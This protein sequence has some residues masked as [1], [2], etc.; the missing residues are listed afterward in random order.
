MKV[1]D[2]IALHLRCIEADLREYLMDPSDHTFETIE[3]VHILLLDVMYRL[4]ITP[5]SEEE[6]IDIDLDGGLSATNEQE[7]EE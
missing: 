6:N 5:E 1:K 2:S 7:K 3:D 4:G